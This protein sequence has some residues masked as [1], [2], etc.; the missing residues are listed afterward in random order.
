MSCFPPVFFVFLL[1]FSLFPTL[2]PVYLFLSFPFSL[3]FT[4]SDFI[5]SLIDLS[6]LSWL[7]WPFFHL[8]VPLPYQSP[9]FLP[10]SFPPDH[11][12]QPQ[13]QGKRKK[14]KVFASL[15]WLLLPKQI[16]AGTFFLPT[17][18]FYF[19]KCHFFLCGC[20]FLINII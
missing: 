20:S 8:F 19:Y 11:P 12:W 16:F 13:L 1:F 10:S 9:S 14:G 7:P 6:I 3:L 4:S 15:K 17:I 5:H 18:F 2:P